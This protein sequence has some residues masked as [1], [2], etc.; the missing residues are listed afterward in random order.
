MKIVVTADSHISSRYMFSTSPN[1]LQDQFYRAA[2]R[3]AKQ[4][5][6]YAIKNNYPIIHGGDW[7]DEEKMSSPEFTATLALFGLV[8]RSRIQMII[9]L[10][11]HEIDYREGV[12]SNLY[13]MV[14]IYKNITAPNYRKKWDLIFIEKL[15]I[16]MI[17][18]MS[19]PEFNET[20][21]A[22]VDQ[23]NPPGYPSALVIH[24]NIKGIKL[25]KHEMQEGLSQSDLQAKIKGK[26]KFVVAGHLHFP[27]YITK[28]DVPVIVP[29]STCSMDFKDVGKTK[30]FGVISLDANYNVQKMTEIPIEG[31]IIFREI[32]FADNTKKRFKC[33]NTVFKIRHS[34]D[35][36]EAYRD[37]RDE[38][39]RQGAI[40]V[41]PDIVRKKATH[42]E[43]DARPVHMTIENWLDHYLEI[44]CPDE[45]ESAA[46]K[47]LNQTTFA[48]ESIL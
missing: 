27:T 31:Q 24:Q 47:E 12:P 5:I 39:I 30:S 16:Y 1:P 17:P 35:Q 40:A 8:G 2:Y 15:A 19:E 23:M 6:D 18:Y 7:F 48:E 10:G 32:D 33:P 28:F 38:M 41:V 3:G 37:L 13:S 14:S 22:L 45:E 44:N 25:G 9:N 26:F 42:Q 4:P 36:K 43:A 34:E 20:L 46:I 29:G 11:N 21:D